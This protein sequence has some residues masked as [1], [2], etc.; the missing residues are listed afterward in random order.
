MPKEITH[1][2][3]AGATASLLADTPWKEPLAA[4][5]NCL[6]LGSVFHDILFYPAGPSAPKGFKNIAAVLHG[7]DGQDTFAVA[8]RILARVPA[9]DNPAPLLAF[10]A[11]IITHIHADAVF[12]PLVYY[13]T[14]NDQNPD[15]GKRDKATAGHRCFETLVDLYF[16]G[17]E[18]VKKFSLTPVARN[19]EAPAETLFTAAYEN[20]PEAK[21][22]KAELVART[23]AC[24]KSFAKLH[25][26][27]ARQGLA[28][29]MYA[30]YGLMP[31]KLKKNAALFYA[32]RLLSF[33]PR[34]E[35]EITY[36]NP[37]TG[38]EQRA[39]LT[40][41]FDRAVRMSAD[42]CGLVSEVLAG[43]SRAK[44]LPKGPSLE[45][46]LVGPQP[47]PRFFSNQD[48]FAAKA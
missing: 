5:P 21:G 41:L 22:R 45:T 8:R 43:R 2:L 34:L 46:G 6:A 15:P 29:F 9:E 42:F 47:K 10:L 3:I 33:L 37:V 12:H 19:L 32:P 48:F 35:R 23:T 26:I 17:L 1:R 39:E 14:G 28:S 44:D 13:L 25:D 7:R 31:R 18:N 38:E 40:T 16:C 20:M 24:L 11:G 27:F 36:Q 4:C 30:A